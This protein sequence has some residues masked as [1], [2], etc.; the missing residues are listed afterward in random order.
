MLF[1][2]DES[3]QSSSDGKSK[4]CVLSAIQLNSQEFNKCSVEIFNLKIK[5]LGY[6]SINSELKGKDLLKKYFLILKRREYNPT[7]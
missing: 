1:F 5:Q 7:H 3:W 4:V 6:N 2:I